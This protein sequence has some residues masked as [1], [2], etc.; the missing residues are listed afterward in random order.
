[1]SL[2]VAPV[3][4]PVPC[5]ACVPMDASIRAC[6]S[7]ENALRLTPLFFVR[8]QE[9]VTKIRRGSNTNYSWSLSPSST[10]SHHQRMP[11][12]LPPP[13][14]P[15]PY[16][17]ARTPW[18]PGGRRAAPPPQATRRALLRPLPPME[19][20]LQVHL[21]RP[22]CLINYTQPRKRLTAGAAGRERARTEAGMIERAARSAPPGGDAFFWLFSLFPFA[23][24][25]CARSAAT[26]KRRTS[27]S[28]GVCVIGPEA[29]HSPPPRLL[30]TGWSAK[31]CAADEEQGGI[32]IIHHRTFPRH[33]QHLYGAAG[34]GRL[35]AGG[36]RRTVGGGGGQ[37][38]HLR[39]R[40]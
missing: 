20:T 25:S 2:R 33:Q 39:R 37:V 1:M 17:P 22:P 23:P 14:C 3:S 29:P 30:F 18:T 24:V 28:W 12:L 38:A 36:L 10:P 35:A 4:S 11:P 8:S 5:Y 9:A 31:Q 16:Q 13:P 40:R 6:V 26:K 7:R 15:P 19:R 34:G 27:A 32:I 21:Q